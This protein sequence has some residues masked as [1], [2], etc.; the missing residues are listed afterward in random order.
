MH[1]FQRQ[2]RRDEEQGFEME[3]IDH[4]VDEWEISRHRIVLRDV[5]GKGA[6]GVVWRATLSQPVGGRAKQIVAAKCFSRN[7]LL[8]LAFMHCN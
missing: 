8:P 1:L 6:F 3:V 2:P 4:E 5:I 7:N